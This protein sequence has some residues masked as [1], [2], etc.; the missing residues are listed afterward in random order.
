[1]TNAG[2][3]HD[4]STEVAVQFKA[5]ASKLTLPTAPRISRP[6]A[7][8]VRS[9]ILSVAVMGLVVPGLFATVALPAYAFR[10]PD[11]AIQ[12]SGELETLKKAD[13]QNLTVAGSASVLSASRDGFGATSPE[14]LAAAREAE[15]AAAAA[16]AVAASG[17]SISDLLANPPYPSFD[18]A[19][20][21][22]VALQYQGVP[23]VYGGATPAGFDCSG[24]VS[25]VYA[26][27]GIALP[28]SVSG[29]AA[30]GTP[31]ATEAALPGDIVTLPGHNGI[32]LGDG[33]FIDAPDYG[34]VVRVRPIYDSGYY[35][36][37]IGI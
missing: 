35:I 34:D 9:G 22:S 4:R 24:F 36:V 20:V 13:A 30:M 23:Y 18:L 5:I 28:H 32:Y 33:M 10:S 15:A 17:P 21:A 19:S 6:S 11:A 2:P 31:I 1:M 26:Q 25:Y 16:A 12:A 37:R 3:E 14:E 29:I 7:K 27:F 8:S